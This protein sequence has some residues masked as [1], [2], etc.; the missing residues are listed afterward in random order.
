MK[1]V[2]VIRD[3]LGR[4]PEPDPSVS[5]VIPTL[6]EAKNIRYVLDNLPAE[7]SEVVVVDG[8]SVDDTIEAA[9]RARSDVRIVMQNRR[10]KGNALACGVAHC[11]GDIVV[12]MDADGSTDPG[13]ILAFVSALRDGADFAKG[14]RFAQGGASLDITRFR[15]LGNRALSG[16]V[17]LLC[18]TQYTDLCYGYNAFWAQHA[19]ALGFIEFGDTG[20]RQQWGDGFEVET[21]MNVRAARVGLQIVEVPSVEHPRIHGVSNL[22]AYT[23]GL[24]VLRTIFVEWRRGMKQGSDIPR[25]T[26]PQTAEAEG[27][28]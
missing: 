2:P 13:E 7:V 10:G 25:Y 19:A 1:L 27:V 18:G 9:R 12:L 3:S 16:L 5:V 11:T 6:N 8:H 22:N 26:L 15:R 24:R 14:S 21:L 4:S 23:D 20:D 17:N 28:A